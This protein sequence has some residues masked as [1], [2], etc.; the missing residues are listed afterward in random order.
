MVGAFSVNDHV[1]VQASLCDFSKFCK[2]GGGYILF[3][4]IRIGKLFNLQFI[5]FNE[6]TKFLLRLCKLP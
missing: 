4:N 5:Q 1:A 6:F 3:V 2:L